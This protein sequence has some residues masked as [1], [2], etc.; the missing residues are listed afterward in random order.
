MKKI[1]FLSILTSIGLSA[2]NSGGTSNSNNNPSLTFNFDGTYSLSKDST[3][4]SNNC[5]VT[6]STITGSALI[7]C[8]SNGA[9]N[10]TFTITY[11][12]PASNTG[13]AYVVVPPTTD[14]YGLTIA[15]TGQGCEQ[16][17]PAA[18]TQYTCHFKI[19]SDGTVDQNQV[20]PILF[21]GKTTTGIPVT[22]S[23]AFGIQTT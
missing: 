3:N 11:K 4:V 17:I 9:F 5:T 14:T 6:D 21:N 8:D 7:K 12:N 16:N 18:D 2:C 1:I 22:T 23:S 19:S 13:A 20:I 10:E 15:G